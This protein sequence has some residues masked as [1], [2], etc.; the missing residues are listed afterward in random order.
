MWTNKEIQ[1][2]YFSF[3]AVI[4]AKAKFALTNRK[5][6]VLR[7]G[8]HNFVAI[9][10]VSVESEEDIRK[11]EPVE[12]NCY[13]KDEHPLKLLKDYTQVIRLANYK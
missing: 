9:S 10:A 13:F 11:I 1:I 7:P 3:V 4:D 6:I 2:P 5:G 8:Q 12:R